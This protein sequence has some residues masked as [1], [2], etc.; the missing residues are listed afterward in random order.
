MVLEAMPLQIGEPLTIIA[1]TGH[2]EPEYITK[3]TENGIDQVFPKPIDI[4]DL[5]Y[6]LVQHQLIECIPETIL[7][8]NQER[9]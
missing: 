1:I 6:I 5:G 7:A 2:A 8:R 9:D 4:L 3:A